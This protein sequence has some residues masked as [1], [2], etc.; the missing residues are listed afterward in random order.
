VRRGRAAIAF[1]DEREA[2]VAQLSVDGASFWGSDE[3]PS[4][5]THSPESL[6]G[7]GAPD[8]DRG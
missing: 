3:A 2:V 6:G 8:P 5:G 7:D 1:Y 4:Y